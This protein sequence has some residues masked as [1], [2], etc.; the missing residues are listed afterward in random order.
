MKR[1]IQDAQIWLIWTRYM[2]IKNIIDDDK[3]IIDYS[4]KRM[5]G[6]FMESWK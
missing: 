6:E 3:L 2:R 1:K 5:N 4:F